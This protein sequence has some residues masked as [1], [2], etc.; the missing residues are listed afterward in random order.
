MVAGF[1]GGGNMSMQCPQCIKKLFYAFFLAV[2]LFVAAQE[3]H[4]QVTV[5]RVFDIQGHAIQGDPRVAVVTNPKGGPDII[6]ICAVVYED[7]VRTWKLYTGGWHTYPNGSGVL[8]STRQPLTGA[9]F[10]T[11]DGHRLE[12]AD[13]TQLTMVEYTIW[14][15]P[16]DI[17]KQK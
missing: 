12:C 17:P 1:F 10:P 9:T 5:Y 4:A 3:A 6:L 2:P 7:G 16:C 11:D 8:T 15:F 14:D 13:G